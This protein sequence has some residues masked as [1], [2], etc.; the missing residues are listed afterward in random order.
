MMSDT[1]RYDIDAAAEAAIAATPS[2][3][4]ACHYIRYA[5]TQRLRLHCRHYV[6]PVD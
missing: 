3:M 4:D 6:T 2:L 5:L 1:L